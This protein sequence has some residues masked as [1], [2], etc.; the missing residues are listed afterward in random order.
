MVALTITPSN[1]VWQ[2]GPI[3]PDQIVGEAADAGSIMYKA[4]NNKWLKAQNDGTDIE[5]GANNLGML[6]ASADANGAR[7]SIALPDAVVAVGAGV[8]GTIYCPGAT[9][10]AL[11]PT[12]DLMS[13]D[14]VT[15]AAIGIGTN[16]LQIARVYNAGCEL[17]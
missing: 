10:G 6:L 5:R 16:K 4:D 13:G 12:A 7:A 17:A 1:V 15:V 9:A 2:S 8:A 11:I 3:A 14:K